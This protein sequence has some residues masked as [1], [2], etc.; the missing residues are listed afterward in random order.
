LAA[1]AAEHR[2]AALVDPGARAA[3]VGPVP[4][5]G[6]RVTVLCAG[7]A[8]AGV[9]AEAAF[10]ARV[11]GAQ[12]VHR[13]LVRRRPD[14]AALAGTDCAVVVTGADASPVAAVRA[15]TSAPVLAVP[16]SAGAAGALGGL[17]ALVAALG[18]GVPV[19]PADDGCAAGLTAARIARG[20][21][22]HDP[23]P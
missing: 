9:A 10:A 7:G 19:V 18:A 16:T 4:A 22:V 12:V 11:A 2:G 17:G 3:A 6:G 8:D 13:D 20:Q 14:P 15:A 21:V 23:L 5:G 1:Q